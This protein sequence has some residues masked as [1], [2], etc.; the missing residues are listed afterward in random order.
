[1]TTGT[2][3]SCHGSARPTSGHAWSLNF[4]GGT[5]TKSGLRTSSEGTTPGI[6][7][8]HQFIGSRDQGLETNVV[9]R[10]RAR[11]RDEVFGPDTDEDNDDSISSMVIL[12]SSFCF[13]SNNY[14]L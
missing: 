1:L 13:L 6:G 9:W 10:G 3:Q 5:S 4:G 2:G 8:G 12:Y 7:G 14:M 11:S